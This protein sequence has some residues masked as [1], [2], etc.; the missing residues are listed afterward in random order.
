MERPA[1]NE[2][3]PGEA[4]HP[5]EALLMFCIVEI[6]LKGRAVKARLRAASARSLDEIAFNPWAVDDRDLR[7]NHQEALQGS[8]VD[9]F[10]RGG[11]RSSG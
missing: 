8:L 5:Q 6:W 9:F 3:D 1:K 2:E 11:M 10:E 4:V 7:L